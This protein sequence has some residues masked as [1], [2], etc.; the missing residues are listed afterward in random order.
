MIYVSGASGFIGSA[1][2]AELSRAGRQY[3]ALEL[4]TDSQMLPFGAGDS[5]VHLA[6]IAHARGVS[7]D[8]LRAVNVDLAVRVGEAAAKAGARMLFLSSVKVHGEESVEPLRE[9]SPIA[10]R[11]PYAQSKALAE[12]RLSGVADLRLTTL[13]PP[14]VYGPR[15]RANFL[16]L[17]KG[18]DRRM[19]L[20]F[21]ALANRRSLIYVGNLVDAILFCMRSAQAVGRCYLLSDGAALS[22]PEL[23]RQIG[24]AL[25][26]PARLFAAPR[27]LLEL[28]PGAKRLTRSLE[29]DDAALRG[30]LGW[31]APFGV[32]EGL[33]ATAAWYRA[34]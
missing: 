31:R 30:D 5:V 23:C 4:R 33:S 11:D 2:C 24:A 13:R 27:A 9:G 1:L 10:P 20:P 22:T 26:R 29:V 7:R 17:M 32:A 28:L 25:A 16:A 19:P 34:R 8:A 3:A 21:G 12:Q 6:A 14:L 15:V 18:I